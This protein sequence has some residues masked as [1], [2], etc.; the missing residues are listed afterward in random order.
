MNEIF[1]KK[2][3]VLLSLLEK[4]RWKWDLAEWIY[5]L[6]NSKYATNEMLDWLIE[7]IRKA[8]K[9]VKDD[10]VKEW[11]DKLS[12]F[13]EMEKKER[14]EWILEAEALLEDIF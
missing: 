13:Q 1:E 4:L 10:L 2:K 7:I 5:V 3:D 12:Q 6:V 11:L 9:N 14:E 8:Y